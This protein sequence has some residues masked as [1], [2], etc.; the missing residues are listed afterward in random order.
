[1]YDYATAMTSCPTGWHLPDTTAW[2]VLE[3][4][5]GGATVAGTMLKAKS[6]WNSSG[7]GTDNYGFSALPGGFYYGTTFGN[8]GNYG[9]W[10]TATPFGNNAYHRDM[11]NGNAIVTHSY[12]GKIYGFSVRCLK[13]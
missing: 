8:V 13:N 6:G 1:M 9:L 2:S 7:N 12:D 5:V 11:F 10:W 3:S 4:A